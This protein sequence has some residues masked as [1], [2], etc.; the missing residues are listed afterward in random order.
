MSH[1]AKAQPEK[2]GLVRSSPTPL[3]KQMAD[4][5]RGKIQRGEL[6]A[7]S[8]LPSEIELGEA[9]GVSRITV[10]KAIE[11]LLK[12]ELVVRARGKGTFVARRALRHEL[13][14]LSGIMSSIQPNSMGPKNRLLAVDYSPAPA[15]IEAI[16]NTAASPVIHFRRIYELNDEPFGL[17]DVFIPSP[18]GLP[19]SA[20]DQVSA[21]ELLSRHLGITATRSDLV[22]K[23]QRAAKDI[24]RLLGL[25]PRSTVLNFRRTSFCAAGRPVEHTSFWVRPDRYEFTLSVSNAMSISDAL[26]TAA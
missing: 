1:A 4:S 15:H 22:I 14:A 8:Q 20:I 18:N 5:L 9:Y 13:S 3:C 24:A 11:I 12:E 23:A 2:I 6:P 16:L 7:D 26:R 25:P 10:R 17:A 21:Y 19:E